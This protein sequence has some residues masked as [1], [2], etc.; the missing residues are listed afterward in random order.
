MTRRTGL[1]AEAAAALARHRRSKGAQPQA[2]QW[3]R[4]QR[5]AAAF[6]ACWSAGLLACWPADIGV[7]HVLSATNELTLT[8]S[9]ASGP[10]SIMELAPYESADSASNAPVVAKASVRGVAI[11]KVP[12]FEGARDRLYSGFLALQSRPGATA[13][14]LG[15]PH[16]VEEFRDVSKDRTP[17]PQAASK[18]GLQIQMTD[19]A[20]AL[21]VKHAAVNFNLASL[22]QV[23]PTP[24]SIP[25]QM[26]GETYY[27]NRGYLE[28]M[29]VKR[30]T[31]AGVVVYLI[32]LYYTGGNREA[33]VFMTHPTC[34][35]QAP[36][37]LTAFNTLT[38]DGLRHFK[39]CMEF[40]ADYFSGTDDSHGRVWGYIL[41][42]EVN[43][44]WE[45]YNLG[46][47]TRD[48]VVN[49]YLR[50]V[51]VAHTALRK[52]SAQARVYLSLTHFWTQIY[53]NNPQH[54]CGG[55]EL[56][57]EFNRL[58]KLGGDFDWNVAHHP[59][60]ENLFECRTWLDKKPTRSPDTPKITFKNLDVLDAYF[61]RPEM[62]YRGRPRRIILSEQGFHCVTTPQGEQ[63]QAAAYCY[64]Y[65]KVARL[66]GIDA[67]I[68]HRQ[69]DNR[70]EGG[71]NLGLWTRQAAS[72]GTPDRKRPIYAV[73][74]AADTAGWEKAFEP[75]LSVIGLTNW[76]Q[77]MT[78]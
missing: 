50:S 57:D 10:V 27:F 45:W 6:L 54:A 26:D 48:T 66:P 73:F 51:R 58:A 62:S 55:K 40:L 67:F 23:K 19:D 22:I 41:G 3:F 34:S 4:T 44:H 72:V 37:R 39:A 53:Q 15:A 28:G 30:F 33:D 61:R 65:L 60:P 25:W 1:A 46:P 13:A 77:V 18:K 12:R 43:T 69:V 71:L 59:Y 38:P 74:Q 7:T 56:I 2:R 29:P 14:P 9:G 11:L 52:S 32:V 75:S 17:F 35:P 5:R 47:A 68:Y 42:N 21:G 76:N 70:G 31:D 49:D 78:K 20:L 36:N 64:S 63:W 8:V 16:F 24:Q